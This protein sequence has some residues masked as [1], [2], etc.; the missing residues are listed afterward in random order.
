[1]L[2]LYRRDGESIFLIED[3][4]IIGEIRVAG[5]LNR[6]VDIRLRM[7][8]EMDILRDE[9]LFRKDHG[10]QMISNWRNKRDD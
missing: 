9:V 10:A 4:E 3:G 8:D 2:K 6:S 1:M 5:I 7:P